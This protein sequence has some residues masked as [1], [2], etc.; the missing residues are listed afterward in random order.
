MENTSGQGVAAVVP[1][2]L[3]R[4]N[5]GAFF[6]NW[7]WGIGNNTFIALLMFVPVVNMVMPFVLGVK[8]SAWAWRN[9]RWESVDHFRRV[10]RN[11]A[12]GGVV[13]I[14][15]LIVFGMGVWFSFTA[16]LN[17]KM[18]RSRTGV[19]ATAIRVKSQSS[20]NINP[21]MNTMVR[22]SITISSVEDEAKSWIVA[23]SLVMVDTSVPILA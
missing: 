23:T 11:W 7:I 17:R 20:Q 16:V 5:W 2:E 3:D 6:L 14:I 18:S 12:I 22:K 21:T 13:A 9:K 4:W 8:G 1:P 19:N 15:A 10:Q